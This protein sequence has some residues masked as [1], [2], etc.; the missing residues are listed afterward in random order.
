[1]TDKCKIS[2][3]NLLIPDIF[4]DKCKKECHSLIWELYLIKGEYVITISDFE[5]VYDQE[6]LY[7]RNTSR[8]NQKES[9]YTT[10]IP[11]KFDILINNE[12]KEYIDVNITKFIEIK[13]KQINVKQVDFSDEFIPLLYNLESTLLSR[14]QKNKY[15][16]VPPNITNLLNFKEKQLIILSLFRNK[17]NNKYELF[18]TDITEEI[19]YPDEYICIGKTIIKILYYGGPGFK[20]NFPIF[21]FENIKIYVNTIYWAVYSNNENYFIKIMFNKPWGY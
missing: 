12:N 2:N 19:K 5:N 15:S 6:K 14:N 20:V 11:Q 3:N 1:M 16:Y 21:L 13:L 18:L 17:R 8:I 10:L 4:I 7:F 9:L